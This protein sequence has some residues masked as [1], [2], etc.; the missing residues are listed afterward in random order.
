MSQYQNTRATLLIKLKNQ[1]DDSAWLEF[2]E[3]YKGFIWSILIKMNV[4][5]HDQNDLAQDILIKAWKN[6]P[7]FDYSR[8]RGKFRNWL[9]LVVSNTVKTYYKK[10]KSVATMISKLD[11]D[12]EIS[13]EVESIATQEWEKFISEK[14]W[15]LVSSTLTDP[16]RECFELISTGMDLNEVAEKTSF[17]YNTVCVYKRRIINKIS[18]EIARLENEIG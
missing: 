3:I 6:L 1:H 15:T 5:A 8:S 2:E 9:G 13:P 16:V 12:G 7:K 18:K 14:A 10:N 17:N 11:D 4:P